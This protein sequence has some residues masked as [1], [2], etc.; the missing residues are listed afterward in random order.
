MTR[1]N[2]TRQF[3]NSPAS[4]TCYLSGG[5]YYTTNPDGGGDPA[6][7]LVSVAFSRDNYTCSF[8]AKCWYMKDTWI[9]EEKE[10]S[11]EHVHFLESDDLVNCDGELKKNSC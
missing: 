6:N 10:T 3:N 1:E 8:W 4:D 5:Q 11:I 9:E 2:C 7:Y